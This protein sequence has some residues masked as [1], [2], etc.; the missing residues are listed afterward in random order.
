MRR[1]TRHAF[2]RTALLL[3]GGGSYGTFHMGVA[4]AMF[5]QHML[6]RYVCS[7]DTEG[8]LCE[9]FTLEALKKM[10]SR[11]R[12]EA[13]KKVWNTGPRARGQTSSKTSAL[14]SH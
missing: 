8:D 13:A 11:L 9:C 7:A 5:D 2:G 10:L 3:S 12:C 1:E 4:K 6:P 14:T